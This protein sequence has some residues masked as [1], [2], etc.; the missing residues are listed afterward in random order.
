M[1]Q[2]VEQ[3]VLHGV[4]GRS[5]TKGINS[6]D[7]QNPRDFTSDVHQTIDDRPF[8]GGDGML[9]M[10]EPLSQCLE[11]IDEKSLRSGPVCMLSPQGRAWTDKDAEAHAKFQEMTLICGRYGGVDQRFLQKYQIQ[12]ISIGDYVLS[13]GELAAG[14][15]IDSVARKIPGVLGH[16]QS[17]FEDS[18]GGEHKLLEAPQFTRPREWQGYEVPRVLL[19]GHHKKIADF[20]LRMRWLVTLQKRPDLVKAGPPKALG[21]VK[22]LKNLSDAEQKSLGLNVEL[23]LETL[24]RRS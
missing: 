6:L 5:F 17:A 8:G 19:E 12:E 21:L 20:Q 10:A 14:V 2:A 24:E 9:M 11:S 4:V 15:V 7:I 18:F 13:G 23:L 1:G 3:A 16:D 22:F